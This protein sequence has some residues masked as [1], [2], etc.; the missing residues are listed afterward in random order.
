MNYNIRD[1]SKNDIELLKEYKRHSIFDYTDNLS[2][3]EIKRINDYIENNLNLDE[4]KIIIVNDNIIGAYLVTDEHLLDE[5]YIEEYWRNQGIGSSIIKDLIKEYKTL[6]LWVYKNNKAVK[7]YESLG[8]KIE[9][10]TDSRYYMV[11]YQ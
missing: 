4:Y 7:L 10:I 6:N 2:D 9:K 5:I 11:Y 1:A 8:F 3:G